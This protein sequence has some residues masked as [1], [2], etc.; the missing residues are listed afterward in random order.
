MTEPDFFTWFVLLHVCIFF[1][2]YIC[3]GF[4]SPFITLI[5]THTISV[6]EVFLFDR[7]ET[8]ILLVQCILNEV[9][10]KV[11]IYAILSA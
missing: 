2:T 11:I 10:T 1:I 6:K 7:S 9:L 4:M 5:A 3:T 8:E